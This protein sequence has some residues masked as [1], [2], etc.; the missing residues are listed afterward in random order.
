M[1]L[2]IGQ[3][4]YANCTP[5]FSALQSSFD[6]SGYRFVR[7]VPSHL[8]RLLA[9]GEIDVCPSSSIEYGKHSDRYLILPDLSISAVGAVK[10]VFLFSTVPIEDLDG[11]VIGMTTESDTSVALLRIIL[12]KFYG[13]ANRFERTPLEI[14]AA[15]DQFP[16][17]L[18]IGD[19]AL[20][21]RL[22]HDG[23][24]VY[25]LGELWHRFTGLPFV[26][27][28]W[29]VRRATVAAFPQEVATLSADLIR[30][31][32][33]AYDS[34]PLIAESAVE[35]GWIDQAMLVDYWR[36]ISY[37]LTPRHLEGVRRFFS[38]AFELGLLSSNPEIEVYGGSS[39]T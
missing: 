1:S 15:L 35:R 14:K 7:G 32:L 31:K 18:L 28:L 2:A 10:S 11:A 37:D 36:T 13:F 39:G 25:D 5:I 17:L 30:A 22:M 12:A 21:G 24:R 6:C 4:E 19:N 9:T 33:L 27:A 34:Y 8:N 26:F 3:I 20:K 38:S 16:G 29:L 23:Y